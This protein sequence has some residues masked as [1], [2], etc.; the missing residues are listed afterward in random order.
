MLTQQNNPRTMGFVLFCLLFLYFIFA[1]F[2][3]FRTGTQQQ[4]I[5]VKSSEEFQENK[6]KK[7][8]QSSNPNISHYYI[9]G[10]SLKRHRILSFD[11]PWWMGA[12][13]LFLFPFFPV[14]KPR[15]FSSISSECFDSFFLFFIFCFFFYTHIL[16]HGF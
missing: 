7:Q 3:F 12:W 9:F 10:Q 15:P 6:T 14:G 11:M 5:S 1:F 2:F 8:S 13:S 4:S 16:K